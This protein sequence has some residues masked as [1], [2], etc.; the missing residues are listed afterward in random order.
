MADE[1]FGE[2]KYQGGAPSTAYA[3]IK[4]YLACGK[5]TMGPTAG[6]GNRIVARIYAQINGDA[7]KAKACVYDNSSFP[8]TLVTNGTTDEVTFAGGVTDEWVT[9]KF[10]VSPTL[11]A[12]REYY[13]VIMAESEVGDYIF[14]SYNLDGGT[15][16]YSLSNTYANGFPSTLTGLALVENNPV[17]DA[18]IYCNY[19][20]STTPAT[21]T[22]TYASGYLT[23]YQKRQIVGHYSSS[24]DLRSVE[25]TA[26]GEIKVSLVSGVAVEIDGVTVSGSVQVSGQVDIG[27]GHV[28][29][30]SGRVSVQSGEV[31]I[32]SGEVTVLGV[33]VSGAVEV[34]GVL[35]IK[36]PESIMIHSSGNPLRLDS[37]SGGANLLSGS[38]VTVTLKAMTSNAGD[39][40]VGGYESGHRP[41]SG[42]GFCLARGEGITVDIENM[43]LIK[44]VA[45]MSGDYISYIGNRNTTILTP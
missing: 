35:E 30:Q 23:R 15:G 6:T 27:Q 7:K 43:G 9:F 26:S 5:F 4:D 21:P 11:I 19:T 29:I 8:P 34:S 20:L 38:C 40:Y 42:Q 2:G 13:L 41:Y 12:S 33:Q 17:G 24:G 25:T 18:C 14:L 36:S 45:A 44:A 31:H 22:D 1:D 10:S 3:E 16:V 32:V 28:A 37:L 39:V